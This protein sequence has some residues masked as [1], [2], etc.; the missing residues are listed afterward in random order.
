MAS[1]GDEGGLL[2]WHSP[3]MQRPSPRI[4]P[5]V[6]YAETLLLSQLS[7]FSNTFDGCSNALLLGPRG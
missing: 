6:L 2:T 7:M 1:L 5:R 4:G 3:A